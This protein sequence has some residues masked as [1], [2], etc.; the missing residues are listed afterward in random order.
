MGIRFMRESTGLCGVRAV[1]L[2]IGPAYCDF[3]WVVLVSACEAT[4]AGTCRKGWKWLKRTGTRG[5]EIRRSKLDKS[6]P[7]VVNLG[8]GLSTYFFL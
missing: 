6:A 5:E 3:G 8:Q 1:V 4:I 7:V 2:K